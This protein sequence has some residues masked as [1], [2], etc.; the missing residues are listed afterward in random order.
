VHAHTY[1][2]QQLAS[3]YIFHIAQVYILHTY[4]VNYYYALH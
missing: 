3:L 4:D 2:A 1:G